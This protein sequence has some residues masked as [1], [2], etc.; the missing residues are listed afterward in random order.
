MHSDKHATAT[1]LVN[2][3]EVSQILGENAEARARYAESL[4]IYHQLNMD[5]AIAYCLEVLAGI[6]AAE[7]ESSRAARLFGAAEWLREEMGT[8]VES[9]N[10]ERYDRDVA[11]VRETLEETVFEEQRAIGRGLARPEAVALA[12]GEAAAGSSL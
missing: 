11:M 7:G 2:L 10:K 1:A 9:F 3:G 5:I 4:T 8:P 12:L 6:D